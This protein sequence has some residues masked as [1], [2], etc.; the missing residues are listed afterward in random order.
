MYYYGK[1]SLNSV[2]KKKVNKVLNSGYISQGKSL[3]DLE[4]KFSKYVG[5][6]YCLAVSSGTAGLH[7][8][9]ASLNLNINSKAVTTP[10]TFVATANACLYSN[11]D[12]D[13]VDID[14]KTLNI[15][16]DNLKKYFEIKSNKKKTK[17][18][19]P[20]HYGGSP[21][22][23]KEINKIAK[24]NKS[25][26]IED[27]SQAMGAFYNKN[28]IGSCEYSDIA[29]FSM[30]PV[31]TITSGEGGLITTNNKILYNKMKLMRSHGLKRS[32]K[33]P[34][35]AEMILFGYNYRITDLQTALANSQLDRI[36]SFLKRRSQISKFYKNRL[37]GDI[38]FQEIYPDSI[39]ANHLFII[40][41]NK[42]ISE[43]KKINFYN[44]LLKKKIKFAVQYLPVHKHKFY[45]KRFNLKFL[46]SEYLYKKS[47]NL[48]IYPDL[49]NNDLEYIV[50]IIN[51][52][53]IKFKL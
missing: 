23:M 2:D 27:A 22:N 15:D 3:T 25:Y 43:K 4:N 21:C 6:K 14:S 24:D 49:T 39:S 42:V 51:K 52:M 11:I 48:P 34:W 40:I 28:K 7:L 37:K 45:K 38:T 19:I 33:Y 8:A 47:I 13:L 9:I 5:A 35:L 17:I 1:N 10:M 32:S 31:K 53:I 50:K 26:V 30:H 44:A 41:F 20:V 18:I 16:T 29:V 36:S 46:N 12:F